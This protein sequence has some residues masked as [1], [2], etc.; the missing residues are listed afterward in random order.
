MLQN[1][2]IMSPITVAI[3]D[4]ISFLDLL[5]NIPVQVMMKAVEML[6]FREKHIAYCVG[7]QKGILPFK[8]NKFI[9]AETKK[10][11][12]KAL[13]DVDDAYKVYILFFDTF[14]TEKWN[15]FIVNSQSR[16][17]EIFGCDYAIFIFQ[18]L[19]QQLRDSF[20]M[21]SAKINLH[22]RV[23]TLYDHTNYYD[24]GVLLFF[25]IYLSVHE[26]FIC[27]DTSDYENMRSNIAYWLLKGNVPL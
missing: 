7:Q 27:F 16:E 4:I 21:S 11:I 8:M 25:T 13:K 22:Q 5:G 6:R 3:A 14:L 18:S 19:D 23:Q 12:S 15:L 2:G 10:D 20:Q 24:T 1:L 9:V 26:V 17:M